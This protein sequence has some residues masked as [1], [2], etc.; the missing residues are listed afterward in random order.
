VSSAVVVGAGV[1]GA[2]IARELGRRGWDVTVVEQYGPGD[3]RS[4][5]GGETRLLRFS[6]G[7][8]EWYARSALRALELWRELEAQTGERLFEP[9]GVAWFD[10]VPGGFSA[11]SEATLARL[12]VATERLTPE[13]ARRL[14]PSLGGDDLCSVLLEP[15][16]GVLHA[17]HATQ[18]LARG[19]RIEARRAA[20]DDPPA[21][22]VVVWA[23]G[24][25]L[26]GLFPGLVR[27]KVSRRDVFFLGADASWAG[28]P[29]FCEYEG[30]F[31]G[32]GQIG[33]L[34]VK[35][36]PDTAG[37]QVDPDTLH[38]LPEPANERLVREYVARR[39]PALAGAPLVG[40][41]VCQYDLTPD[42]NFVVARHPEREGWWLVGGG[43]GHGFKHGP[44]LAEYVADCVEGRR[45]P[46][47]FHG[48]GPREP[49]AGL[50]TSTVEL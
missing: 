3:V 36:A 4:G 14:Y 13:E 12:G 7:D 18:A 16:A 23:C 26:A 49:R 8:D 29:G 24:S 40:A 46:E 45:E 21:G 34:G 33:G 30:L 6:H 50:R 22:D 48:L 9:V 32:H 20:P 41:S 25:W 11:R 15:G 1:F 10:T 5:S 44:A 35:I 17:R 31:Y 2:S 43:S 37:E 47:P 38:R 27:Q 19:L 42:A 39:F 28:A